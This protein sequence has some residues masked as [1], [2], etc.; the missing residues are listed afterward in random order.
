MPPPLLADEDKWTQLL[1]GDV[2]R[3]LKSA[4]SRGV[5]MVSLNEAAFMHREKGEGGRAGA[6]QDGRSVASSTSVEI[7]DDLGHPWPH[8]M[9]LQKHEEMTAMAGLLVVSGQDI[10]ATAARAKLA[11]LLA[12]GRSADQVDFGCVCGGGDGKVVLVGCGD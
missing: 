2:L 7:V 9:L 11:T 5:V 6:P 8:N 10:T 1:P 12:Q 4:E 3:E